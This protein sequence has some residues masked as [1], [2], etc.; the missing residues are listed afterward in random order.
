[1]SAD[2]GP[3]QYG[4]FFHWIISIWVLNWYIGRYLEPCL[5]PPTWRKLPLLC[6]TI[7]WN[8]VNAV[9]SCW[10]H[11][12]ESDNNHLGTWVQTSDE[13]GHDAKV[14]RQAS[15]SFFFSWEFQ[16]GQIG[17]NHVYMISCFAWLRFV[18]KLDLSLKVRSLDSLIGQVHIPK[19]NL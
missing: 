7:I 11:A 12:I 6:R 8:V 1:M 13:C 3:N 10:T 19:P 4:W 18:L 14:T 17:W 15:E 5:E 16:M 9:T 2:I